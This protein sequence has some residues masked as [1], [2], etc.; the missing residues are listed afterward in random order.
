MKHELYYYL[1]PYY[2]KCG[3]TG[4]LPSD[5]K[6]FI[7]EDGGCSDVESVVM[8]LTDFTSLETI[9]IGNNAYSSVS[10]LVLT[11]LNNLVNLTIG[12][13]C[14]NYASSLEITGLTNLV[15]LTIGN[16]CFKYVTELHIEDLSKLERVT[17]GSA[18]FT[19]MES[20]APSSTS[21]KKL[22]MKNCPLLTEVE[23]GRY[24]FSDYSYS[25]VENLASLESIVFGDKDEDSYNFYNAIEAKFQSD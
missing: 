23:I 2:I 17:I 5:A 20:Y 13:N 8:D 24:A 16:S 18:S 12:D 22:Y 1:Q 11:G 7:V 3:R 10:S 19:E 15:N 9:S 14:F 6:D 4:Y 25:Y 21:S